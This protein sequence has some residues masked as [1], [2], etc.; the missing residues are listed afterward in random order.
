MDLK[1]EQTTMTLKNSCDSQHTQHPFQIT[2]DGLN[3][4][5][6]SENLRKCFTRY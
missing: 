1:A 2:D 4:R 3:N 5:R 6:K